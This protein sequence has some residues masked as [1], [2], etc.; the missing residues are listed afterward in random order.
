[1]PRLLAP[2]LLAVCTLPPWPVRD[3]Y[4]LRVANLLQGLAGRWD[5]TLLAPGG[6]VPGVADWAPL[7][8][9]GP[10]VSYPW[11]FD[12]RPLAAAIGAAARVRPPDRALVWPG[13]EAAWL[14][15]PGRPPAVL[16]MIDCNPLEFARAARAAPG[17]RDRA[18]NATEA[19][20]AA[21][22][23][24][25]AVRGFGATACVREADAAWLARLG[26]RPV[27]VMPNGVA[28]PDRPMPEDARPTVVFAGTL[29]Y[30]PNV[31]AVAF[32]ARD[33]WPRVR[34]MAPGAR[35]VIAG[36]RPVAA[37]GA[38]H[39]RDGIEVRPD[40]ADMAAEVG[41]GW[42]AVA[43]MR[44][45]VGL[46][47]KVLE[48]WA[49]ARPVVLTPMATNGLRMPPGHEAL[50]QAGGA[51]IADA[52]VGLLRDGAA[53]ARLGDAGDGGARLHLGGGRGADGRAAAG[54]DV[55]GCP[56]ASD[57]PPAGIVGP[58]GLPQLVFVKF[59]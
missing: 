19:A 17:W 12:D 42:V 21:R 7:A 40:V 22:H 38:L 20:V 27:H 49:C 24:R 14:A 52:V 11:R 2:R 4:S 39:G 51:G 54:W 28:L 46:K 35:W 16:D 30:A 36:R 48:A 29:D 18:R 45:G 25:R 37:I 43:P 47:N 44:T 33:V 3:G 55:I 56:R 1:M 57:E 58:H 13:A 15:V 23:A 8:V 5:V 50:V 9:S 32:M 41:A 6:G 26:G 53:R 59:P 10:G 31:D 34:G